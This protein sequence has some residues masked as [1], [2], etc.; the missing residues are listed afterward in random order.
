MVPFNLSRADFWCDFARILTCR[1]DSLVCFFI[2]RKSSKVNKTVS[3]VLKGIQ[4][5][6]SKGRGGGGRKGRR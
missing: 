5:G 4:K 3:A 6:V 1:S 2:C